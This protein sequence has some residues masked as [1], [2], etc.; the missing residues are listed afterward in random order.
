MTP[1]AVAAFEGSACAGAVMQSCDRGYKKG[2]IFGAFV[3][4]DDG[5]RTHDLLHGKR[6]VVSPS[7]ITSGASLSGNRTQQASTSTAATSGAAS[8]AASNE[9]KFDGDRR[10]LTHPA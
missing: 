9:F 7:R 5:S 1:V 4:A 10:P 6:V 2:P 8:T 3:R